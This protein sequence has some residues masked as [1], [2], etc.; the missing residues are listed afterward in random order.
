M[1]QSIRPV[2][3]QMIAARNRLF[4]QNKTRERNDILKSILSE[5]R[6]KKTINVDFTFSSMVFGGLFVRNIYWI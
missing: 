3:K 5:M 4:I 1:S 6:E 2:F